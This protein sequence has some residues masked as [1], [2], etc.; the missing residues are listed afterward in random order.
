MY[1]PITYSLLVK[2]NACPEQLALF[3]KHFG[4]TKAIP[5]TKGVVTQFGCLFDIDW[6]A[7]RLLTNADFVEYNK[8]TT[9]A[10]AEYEKRIVISWGEYFNHS[11]HA[12][13][14]KEHD[15]VTAIAKKEYKKVAATKF[16]EIYKRGMKAS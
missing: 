9:P 2:N 15:K 16:V 3:E 13:A 4:K 14:R 1:Q 7:V 12:I 6:A 5:L 10:A 8:F 11:D